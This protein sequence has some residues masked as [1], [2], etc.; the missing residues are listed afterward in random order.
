MYHIGIII[1]ET[2]RSIR[3]LQKQPSFPIHHVCFWRF[4]QKHPGRGVALVFA[5]FNQ[6]D[7]NDFLIVRTDVN[8]SVEFMD[9][10]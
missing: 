2:F 7:N 3:R 9:C 5:S 6:L 4:G 10:L 8:G 1:M